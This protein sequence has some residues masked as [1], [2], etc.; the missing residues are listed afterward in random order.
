MS[1]SGYSK[2]VELGGRNRV[3]AR[4]RCRDYIFHLVWELWV[5]H[6][7]LGSGVRKKGIWATLLRRVPQGLRPGKGMDGSIFVPRDWK[8]WA[9]HVKKQEEEVEISSNVPQTLIL[10]TLP[11]PSFICGRERCNFRLVI[12]V[13]T[14]FVTCLHLELTPAA[15]MI[16]VYM[17]CVF[18]VLIIYST[19]GRRAC[20]VFQQNIFC[21]IYSVCNCWL[22]KLVSKQSRTSPGYL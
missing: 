18:K 22:L 2:H 14:V 6:E 11:F 9:D 3:R 5:P 12:T 4:T 10:V 15:T 1:L 8:A 21:L 19:W 16:F 13:L 20:L 7:A 17:F